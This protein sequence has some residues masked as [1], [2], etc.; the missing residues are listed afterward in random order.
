MLVKKVHFLIH[1]IFDT[2]KSRL[3]KMDELTKNCSILLSKPS[4][5]NKTLKKLKLNVFFKQKRFKIQSKHTS[6]KDLENLL[7]DIGESFDQ[8]TNIKKND[9]MDIEEKIIEVE[10]NDEMDIE[11]KKIETEEEILLKF[12]KKKKSSIPQ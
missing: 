10:K 5:T 6:I 4:T 11:E 9:E 1:V 7:D 12:Q 2:M 8:K 3:N